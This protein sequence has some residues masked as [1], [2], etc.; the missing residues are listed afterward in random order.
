MDVRDAA[1]DADA[2]RPQVPAVVADRFAPRRWRWFWI[3]RRCPIFRGAGSADAFR[4]ADRQRL[5]HGLWGLRPPELH[6]L[7]SPQGWSAPAPQG[8]IA[9]RRCEHRENLPGLGL[10]GFRSLRPG[11]RRHCGR[12]PDGD[13]RGRVSGPRRRRRSPVQ[14]RRC[15]PAA[16][17]R[18]SKLWTRA[19]PHHCLHRRLRR[20]GALEAGARERRE[21][22][23]VWRGGGR[24]EEIG[25]L[26][27]TR[28]A[29]F[30]HQAFPFQR[31]PL[32]E[33]EHARGSALQGVEPP[34]L[35]R[36]PLCL[37]LGALRALRRGVPQRRHERW[38]LHELLRQHRGEGDRVAEV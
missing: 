2:P 29:T 30:A 33:V 24:C 8:G 14:F 34:A 20:A 27:G 4:G 10:G 9:H 5:R 35:D 7:P 15:A 31:R 11:V 6:R 19:G 25:N 3:R 21:V 28:R 32:R 22:R 13:R 36:R 1:R 18:L 26:A 38:P 17:R 16:G 12:R 23:E 37:E